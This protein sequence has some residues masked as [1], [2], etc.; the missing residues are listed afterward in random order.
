MKKP[1]K[2]TISKL[3]TLK[4]WTEKV[5]FQNTKWYVMLWLITTLIGIL[6]II[7]WVFVQ[8]WTLVTVSDT[9]KDIK[10]IQNYTL[11]NDQSWISTKWLSW[12]EFFQLYFDLLSKEDYVNVCWLESKRRC[13]KSDFQKLTQY[14]V[15]K[16]RVW[17]TKWNDWE[18]LKEIQL[19]TK[20]PD[21]KNLESWCVKTEYTLKWETTSVTQ[22]MRYDILTRPTW[23]KQIATS[24]CE[25][26]IKNGEDRTK[27]MWCGQSNICNK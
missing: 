26:T 19:A 7:V 20:Q 5:T 1:S 2:L 13:D 10:D 21:A 24:L 6:T 18:H 22:L 15:D 27:Q 11:Y 8:I 25:K 9:Q 17:F 16:N 14:W 23:E 12:E 3:L 4:Y